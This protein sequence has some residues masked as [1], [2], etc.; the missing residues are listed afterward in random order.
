MNNQIIRNGPPAWLR[1]TRETLTKEA[2]RSVAATRESEGN[3]LGWNTA[4]DGLQT[5]NGAAITNRRHVESP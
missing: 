1:A 2:G 4:G 3:G 5:V